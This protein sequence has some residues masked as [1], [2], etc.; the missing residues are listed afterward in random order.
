MVPTML[1]SNAVAAG[2]RIYRSPNVAPA[3]EEPGRT[4]VADPPLSVYEVDGCT[5]K[6]YCQNLCLLSKLFLDHKTLYFDV[7][8]FL[9]YVFCEDDAEG[10]DPT[11]SMVNA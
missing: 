10:C 2:Q 8:P 5:D 4:A 7:E 1:S 3:G 9:F 11:T 6:I